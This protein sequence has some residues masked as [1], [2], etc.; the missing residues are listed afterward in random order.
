ME[1]DQLKIILEAV[2]NTVGDAKTV[3]LA[4]LAVEGVNI[5]LGYIMG[6]AILTLGYKLGL[7]LIRSIKS[8]RNLRELRSMV[9]IHGFD[10]VSPT[11]LNRI[12]EVIK[13]G[14]KSEV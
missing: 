10:E 9:V 2:N 11:E 4:W 14:L 3:A 8:E 1:I 7:R 13:K 6:G 12:K 5:L